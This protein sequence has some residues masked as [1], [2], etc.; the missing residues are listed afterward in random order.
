MTDRPPSALPLEALQAAADLALAH[1]DV[2]GALPH[3]AHLLQGLRAALGDSHPHTLACA[4]NLGVLLQAGGQ[5]GEAEALFR[6]ELKGCQRALGA[7]HPN[8]KVSARNL[9]RFLKVHA[10][11]LGAK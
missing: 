6:E 5:L 7:A 4:N 9:Q 3:Y 1:N 2:P 8:T 10:K 11:A